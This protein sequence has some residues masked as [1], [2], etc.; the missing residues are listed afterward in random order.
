VDG[1]FARNERVVCL[2]NDGQQSFSMVLVGALFVG[3]I[4]TVWHGEI[5]PPSR[6]KPR[7][8]GAISGP[9]GRLGRGELMG[10]FNMGSTVVLLFP[11]GRVQWLASL[12]AGMAIRVGQ[13]LGRIQPPE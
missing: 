13:P 4:S 7:E 8:L 12:A 3:S 5:T 1:L 9:A 2:W 11:K 6:R 10:W